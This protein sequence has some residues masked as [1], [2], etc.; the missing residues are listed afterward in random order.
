MVQVVDRFFFFDEIS[1]EGSGSDG[2]FWQI[3]YFFGEVLVEED[4]EAIVIKPIN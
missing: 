2:Y 3:G 4:G 1:V